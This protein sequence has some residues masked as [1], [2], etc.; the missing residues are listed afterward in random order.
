MKFSWSEY[1]DAC[2]EYVQSAPVY[3]SGVQFVQSGVTDSDV[4]ATLMWLRRKNRKDNT[5]FLLCDSSTDSIGCDSEYI[6]TGKRGR[7]KK[8]VL[9]K[10]VGRH[11][12]GIL[13]SQDQSAD[14]IKNDLTEYIQKRRKRNS[15]LKQQKVSELNQMYI[16]KY[17]TRQADHI[18]Q[19]ND[20]DFDYFNN[21]L[22]F[23]PYEDDDFS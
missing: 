17:I 23:T 22:Y 21:D 18:Y 13:I 8:T 19:S 20:F 16:V 12:H 5:S 10:K 1:I 14:A 7:P 15:T 9:G 3:K 4:M 11:I 2:K 6:K